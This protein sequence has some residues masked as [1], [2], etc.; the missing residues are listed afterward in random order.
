[1]KTDRSFLRQRSKEGK[2]MEKAGE[3]RSGAL[4]RGLRKLS[5]MPVIVLILLEWPLFALLNPKFLSANNILSLFVSNPYFIVAAIGL[6]FVFLTGGIDLSIGQVVAVSSIVSSMAMVHFQTA[7]VNAVAN[8]GGPVIG[9][10]NLAATRGVDAEL[11]REMIDSTAW[12]TIGLGLAVAIAV[13]AVFG[14]ING[15]AVGWFRIAPFIATLATQ[16]TA[17]GLSLVLTQGV[18]VSGVP[19]TLTRMSINIGV[20][21]GGVTIPWAAIIP[22][23]LVLVFGLVQA[24]T[25]WGRQVILTGSN[26]VAAGYIG[27]KTDR[28]LFSV[29]LLSGMLAGVAGLMVPMCL[30]AADPKVGSPMLLPIVGAIT[31]GGIR[32][33]GGHGNML[34]AALGIFMFI[35]LMNGMTYMNL[36]LPQQQLV[37]GL[38]LI[39]STAAMARIRYAGRE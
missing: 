8:P 5:E 26:S 28:V 12:P 27:V 17:R 7:W 22:W 11:V 6:F 25:T 20:P 32:D 24:K 16:L 4:G 34:Y 15:V 35:T 21:I 18:S 3:I 10:R 1:M 39:I 36:N 19:R 29:Y 13:G 23:L 31:I 9:L 14:A 30:G 33:T 2:R 38:I 37:Y